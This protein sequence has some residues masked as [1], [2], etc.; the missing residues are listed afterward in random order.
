MIKKQI[1]I[2]YHG[3][4]KDGF[5]AAWAAWKKFGETATYIPVFHNEPMP[6]G[7]KNKEIYLLDFCFD[8]KTTKELL[9][10]NKRVTAIDH[11]AT[12]ESI[13]KQTANYSYALDHSGCVL[14]WNYFHPKK[15][16]PKLLAYVED[17]D[18]WAF[19]VPRAKE[20]G[21]F[22]DSQKKEFNNWTK[23][24][25]LIEN[26]ETRAAI[27]KKGELLLEF[28]DTLMERMIASDA[29][30]VEFEGYKIFAINSPIFR[31]KMGNMLATDHPPMS[32]VWNDKGDKRIVSLRSIPKFDVEAIAKKYGG[33]GHKNAA[34]FTIATHKPTPWKTIE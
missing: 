24:A 13:V 1:V 28:E 29:T 17:M 20:I 25:K 30:L 2:L 23:L 32:I 19:R 21:A 10:A 4:C 31:S 14:A 8:E 7:L 9:S 15:A 33:G 3:E 18:L 5:S 22:L 16:A 26:A 6:D 12:R 27:I 11:H 34:G